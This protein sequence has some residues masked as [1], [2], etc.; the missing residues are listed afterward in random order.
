MKLRIMLV[1]V[2]VVLLCLVAGAQAQ[3]WVP[4][5]EAKAPSWYT[6]TGAEYYRYLKWDAIGS[7]VVAS[8]V[9]NYCAS[10]CGCE[11]CGTLPG[12]TAMVGDTLNIT[13]GNCESISRVKLLFAYITGTG[14]APVRS[15][16]SVS[17]DKRVVVRSVRINDLGGSWTVRIE[18]SIHPQPNSET[19]SIAM[20]GAAM[21]Q[22]WAGSR[23][24]AETIPTLTEWGLII[25]AVLLLA[26]MTFVL[27][28]RR[29]LGTVAA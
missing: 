23:C 17:S 11:A 19:I 4:P 12:T 1:I 27:I 14:P 18:A 26:T 28:R 20:P 22:C 15:G 3:G 7:Y 8:S 10:D 29:R 13:I 5:A 9:C 24:F 21:S 16:I 25:L 2:S 6:T